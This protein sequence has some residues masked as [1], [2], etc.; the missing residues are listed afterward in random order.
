M[1]VITG[2]RAIEEGRLIALRWALS[3]ETRGL[4]RRGAPA[5]QLVREATGLKT[6]KKSKLLEEYDQWLEEKGVRPRS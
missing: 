4:K 3:L 2:G 6:R 1:V 5:S